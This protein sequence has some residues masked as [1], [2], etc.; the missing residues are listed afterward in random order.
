MKEIEKILSQYDMLDEKIARLEIAIDDE[1][2]KRGPKSKK[3]KKKR[4]QLED[5]HKEMAKWQEKEVKLSQLG[6]KSSKEEPAF[7]ISKPY[8]GK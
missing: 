6:L 7:D 8:V 4:K 2:E 1:I 3:L 5:A